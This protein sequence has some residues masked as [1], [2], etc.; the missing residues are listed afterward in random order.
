MVDFHRMLRAVLVM[1]HQRL[2]FKTSAIQRQRPGFADAAHVRQRLFDDDA[3]YACGIEN[4]KHQIKVA[5]A[6]LLRLYQCGWIIDAAKRSGVFH[7]ILGGK[8]TVLRHCLFLTHF[9]NKDM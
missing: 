2:R 5:V 3:A 8:G 1:R 4:L 9:T 7:G 6:H